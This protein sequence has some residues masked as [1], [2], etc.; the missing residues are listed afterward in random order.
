MG[1]AEKR[2]LELK[3]KKK[4]G[5]GAN[6][7][8]LFGEFDDENTTVPKQPLP[9]DPVLAAVNKLSEKVDDIG[10]IATRVDALEVGLAGVQ[11]QLAGM[12]QQLPP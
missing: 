1:K 7:N 9:S 6:S 11:K 5:K 2:C 8:A 4:P 10:K 3:K 12:Q